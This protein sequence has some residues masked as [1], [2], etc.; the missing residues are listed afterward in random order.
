M[1]EIFRRRYFISLSYMLIAV[2]GVVA[3][4]NI[5][6]EMAPDLRLP[7]VTV[8]YSWGSTSPEVMEQEVTRRVEQSANRLRNVEQIR[9]VTR[10]GRSQVTITF[11]KE[12]PV[13]Y[14]VLELQEYLYALRETLPPQE[15]Q[16]SINRSIPQEL[17]EQETFMAWSISGNRTSRELYRFA[18]Q[19]IELQLLGFE[20]LAEIEIQGAEDPAL[21]IRFNRKL[22]EQYGVEPGPILDDIRN[23]LNWRSTGFVEEKGSRY[24]L[25]IPPRFA[26]LD[27]IREMNISLPGSNR[28]VSLREIAEISVEDYPVKSLK[29]L[30]G[31][32]ALSMT[33]VRE[34]GSDAMKLAATLRA[35]MKRIEA[36]LPDDITLQLER[37]STEELR[38]QFDDLQYQSVF[39][40]L[41]VFIILLLFIRRVRAPFVILGSILFSLLMSI[42]IL[43]FL[44]Y[45]MN[46]LTLAGLTVALGMIIDNA[47]VVFEQLNPGLPADRERRMEHVKKELPYTF[48][49]VLGSTLTTI[50]IFVPLFFAME[51]LQ[52]FLVPLAVAL[53]LTLGSSVLVALSWI[54]YS[55][56]WLVPAKATGQERTLKKRLRK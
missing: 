33:F 35:E 30:N 11:E 26:S 28:Q 46:V 32:P 20:G 12:T 10:E 44:N 38:A 42:S 31:K 15:R 5:P 55:L 21:T 43:F 45:T 27:D 39:S 23:R 6:L 25:L 34:S 4:L 29:R 19:R 8:S 9:S 22:I 49:P 14:R 2:V 24:S 53:T 3:W 51:E 17:Q 18:R 50:G 48:V 54:P 47:V 40:I 37:D 36:T 13:E 56:I 16:P 7:S 41:L 52:L 1:T